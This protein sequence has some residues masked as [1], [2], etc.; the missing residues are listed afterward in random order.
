MTNG[1]IH[2]SLVLLLLVIRQLKVR[3]VRRRQAHVIA[4]V[5]VV[6][7]HMTMARRLIVQLSSDVMQKVH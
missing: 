4:V 2:L 3:I 6:D 1:S 7:R 5:V